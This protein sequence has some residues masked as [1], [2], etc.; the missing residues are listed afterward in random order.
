MANHADFT[1][2]RAPYVQLTP[3][4]TWVQKVLPQV[5]DDSLSYYELLSRVLSCL[6]TMIDD[7]NAL[8]EDVTNIYTAFTQLQQYVNDYFDNLDVGETLEDLLDRLI[9][10][11]EFNAL[12]T[13]TTSDVVTQWMDQ[14]VTPGQAVIDDT[15][16]I[17]GAAADA[18]TVG[19][20]LKTCYDLNGANAEV[21]PATGDMPRDLNDEYFMTVGNYVVTSSDAADHILNIPTKTAGRLLVTRNTI[22]GRRLQ[23][24]IPN[25]KNPRIYARYYDNTA[26][27]PWVM[28]G[29]EGSLILNGSGAERI[30]NTADLN[31]YITPGNYR[32][33][34]AGDAG[35]IGHTPV[36]NGGRLTVMTNNQSSNVVQ[37]FTNNSTSWPR[38]YY[39]LGQPD[40]QSPGYVFTDWYAF[41]VVQPKRRRLRILLVGNSYSY[42]CAHYIARYLHDIGYDAIVGCWYYGASRLAQTYA[43]MLQDTQDN[44]TGVWSGVVTNDFYIWDNSVNQTVTP[45]I[46]FSECLRMEKWNNV[47]FQQASVVAGQY[48]SYV[49]DEFDIKDLRDKIAERIG[50]VDGGIRWAVLLPWSYA[51]GYQSEA[52]EEYYGSD[53]AVQLA[54]NIATVPK[55]CNHLG[56]AYCVNV[57]IAVQKAR[58]NIYLDAIGVDL[59]REWSNEAEQ[60]PDLS[61][62]D[63]G[64]PRQ[65]A[66]MVYAATITGE[67]PFKFTYVSNPADA[68]TTP[69]AFLTNLCQACTQYALDWID[70]ITDETGTVEERLTALES[71]VTQQQTDISGKVDRS[72]DT[73]NGNL[74][75]KNYDY[76][77]STGANDQ[78]PEQLS[79]RVSVGS[80]G[81]DGLRC[82]YVAANVMNANAESENRGVD[83]TPRL[84]VHGQ[85]GEDGLSNFPKQISFISSVADTR[86]LSAAE[87]AS[88][89]DATDTAVDDIKEID[90]HKYTMDTETNIT[91]TYKYAV[92]GQ[93]VGSSALGDFNARVGSNQDNGIYSLNLKYL[94]SM[95]IKAV[96]ELDA[97]ITT[98]ED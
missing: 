63:L 81:T 89:A 21:I 27:Q 8:G 38:V 40:A 59:C 68:S 82:S 53:P 56:D 70:V 51:T 25:S 29:E 17:S 73:M 15:L 45:G 11:G 57:G 49:S 84:V 65:L 66:A 41:D 23:F 98:L 19:N 80:Y 22:G 97:R 88:I 62:L 92:F 74:Y 91:F 58:G 75:E 95:L 37:I 72:G 90:V 35:N 39:R 47:I 16:S 94:V 64:I 42:H 69:T 13:E 34:N 9:K 6:N 60:I 52:Y 28:I 43:A 96:Q 2:D 10:T 79:K 14:H 54:A 32:I 87:Q 67:D 36:S 86:L 50:T 78:D 48:D 24:Y 30:P 3:F 77:E 93:D 71:A 83:L 31:D 61:H 33:Y 85:W 4:R 7:L 1:P 5:Y 46:C 12:F 18:R 76:H 44:T 20:R 55:V 26:W